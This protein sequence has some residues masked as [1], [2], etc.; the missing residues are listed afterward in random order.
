MWIK[1]D[2]DIYYHKA[3]DKEATKPKT[4]VSRPTRR[5]PC[6]RKERKCPT[7]HGNPGTEVVDRS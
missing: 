4:G 1:T 3:R 6:Q 7:E 2:S 5:D